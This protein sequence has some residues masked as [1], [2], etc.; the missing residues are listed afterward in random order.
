MCSSTRVRITSI[1]LRTCRQLVGCLNR[2]AAKSSEVL[3]SAS[4]MIAK[5]WINKI[6]VTDYKTYHYYV[7]SEYTSDVTYTVCPAERF[8]SCPVGAGGTLRK[9]LRLFEMLT[10]H[11][12][13]K[14]PS[15]E[16]QIP[17]LSC[18][19]KQSKRYSI[20]RQDTQEVDIQ[21]VCGRETYHASATTYIC[22]CCTF[23]HYGKCA[24]L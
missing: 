16:T 24:C 17:Y 12:T 4:R 7:P 13:Q 11:D 18:A 23:S 19:I 1:S 6:C 3:K 20:L 21:S 10:D 5:G 14:F 22:T 9:H 2:V 8:C 15:F